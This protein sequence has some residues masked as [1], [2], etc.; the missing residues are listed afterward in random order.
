MAKR[1]SLEE[2]AAIIANASDSDLGSDIVESSDEYVCSEDSE[3]DTD[4]SEDGTQHA[5]HNAGLFQAHHNHI[6][7]SHCLSCC[8][9]IF[10]G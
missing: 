9:Q 3:D 8:S 7:N 4:G 5:R 6:C 2:A 10:L 1:F